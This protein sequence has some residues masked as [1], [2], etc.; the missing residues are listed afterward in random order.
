MTYQEAL[1]SLIDQMTNEGYIARDGLF[2]ATVRATDGVDEKSLLA[3]L[4]NCIDEALLARGALVE[5]DVFIVDAE[6]KVHSHEQN[7]TPAKYLAILELQSYDAS[8]TFESCR[9]HSL[10]EIRQE[11]HAHMLDGDH[12]GESNADVGGEHAGDGSEHADANDGGHI[13]SDGDHANDSDDGHGS[14]FSNQAQWGENE[15]ENSESSDDHNSSN[16][17]ESLSHNDDRAR[18]EHEDKH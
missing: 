2:S 17:R 7:V 12:T 5:R 13:D 11:T 15:S 8:V 4:E 14:S 1:T 6:T 16:N 9:D 10:G 3:S 18:G